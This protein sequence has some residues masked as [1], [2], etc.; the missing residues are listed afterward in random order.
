MRLFALKAVFELANHVCRKEI[1]ENKLTYQEFM[2]W[3]RTCNFVLP[4]RH[5]LVVESKLD[6][7][8]FEEPPNPF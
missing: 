2:A 4:F 5:G 3:N 1:Y 7:K 6:A 8:S